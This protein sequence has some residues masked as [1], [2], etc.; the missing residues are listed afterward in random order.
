MVLF[1]EGYVNICLFADFCTNECIF[2]AGNKASAADNQCIILTLTAFES[3]TINEAFK[4]DNCAVTHLNCSV[5]YRNHTSILLL[6]SLYLS[7]DV[8]ILCSIYSFL[9]LNALVFTKCNLRLYCNCSCDNEVFAFADFFDIDFRLVNRFDTCFFYSEL[10]CIR[11][12]EIYC[13]FIEYSFAVVLFYEASWSLTFSEAGYVDVFN[14]LLIRFCH[15]SFKG[16]FVN[17]DSKLYT[18]FLKLFVFE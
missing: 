18:V 14:I 12:Y 11:T 16:F 5:L 17:L 13:I 15:S 9:Y 1:R 2:K 7:I 3:N 6:S 10:I 8:L 4:I